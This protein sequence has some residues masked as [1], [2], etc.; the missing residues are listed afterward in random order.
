VRGLA[1]VVY[2]R[3]LYE[4]MRYWDEDQSD[5]DAEERDFAAALAEATEVGRVTLVEVVGP[6]ATLVGMT[7]RRRSAG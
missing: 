6:N 5:W 2:G 7:L 3:R 1:G 4:I